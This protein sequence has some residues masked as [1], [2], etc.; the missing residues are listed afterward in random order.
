MQKVGLLLSLHLN[1]IITKHSPAQTLCLLLKL[2]NKF[3]RLQVT[4]LK[5]EEVNHTTTTISSSIKVL[6]NLFN[7][8]LRAILQVVEEILNFSRLQ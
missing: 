5:S 2:T 1:A 3:R 7:R 4:K 8:R 6:S